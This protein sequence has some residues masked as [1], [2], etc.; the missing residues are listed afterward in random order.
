MKF[1]IHLTFDAPAEL[2]GW[3]YSKIDGDPVLGGGP[4]HYLTSYATSLERALAKIGD[5]R[6]LLGIRFLADHLLRE[7]IEQ[8]VHDV[9]YQPNV[10]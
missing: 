8:I 7:K 5:A 9:R 2:P 1:E 6:L 10:L 4:R 3:S